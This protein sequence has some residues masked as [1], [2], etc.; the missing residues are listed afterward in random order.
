[1]KDRLSIHIDQCCQGDSEAFG[2]IVSEY[3]QM[4]Y[5]LAFRLLCDEDDAKD[6]TQET[7]IKAW[8]NIRSYKREYRF[9]T[10]LYKIAMNVCYDKMRSE[11]NISKVALSD[12]NLCIESDPNE[13]LNNK[14]LKELILRITEGLTP[15]QKLVF[16]LSDLEEFE[17]D[18]IVI[19]TGMSAAKI[20]SNLYLAR[21]YIKSKMKDYER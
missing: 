11:R 4:I 15:K 20:K 2:Y 8:Q 7:L 5:T 13:Q 18:E 12:C 10:W 21:K 14:E 9:T 17:T 16:T 1:M 3:Q 19:I 6:A